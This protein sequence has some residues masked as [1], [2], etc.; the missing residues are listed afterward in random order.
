MYGG[1]AELP[2]HC[3]VELVGDLER[4]ML[5]RGLCRG[6][7]HELALPPVVVEVADVGLRRHG[8]GQ[9]QDQV[10]Q[11]ERARS[12]PSEPLLLHISI[13]LPTS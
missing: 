11:D 10:E 12:A 2:V 3:A 5:V 4:V 7:G 1:A 9:E 8:R 13:Y 6:V